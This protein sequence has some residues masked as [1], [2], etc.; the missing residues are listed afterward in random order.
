MSF[1][2]HFFVGLERKVLSMRSP[3]R[4]RS[5]FTLIELLVVIAII[6]ILIA[7]LLPAVQQAR[8]AARRS[9]CKNNL[10]QL[11]LALHNY[12][13][14][15]NQF[16]RGDY[17]VV[18]DGKLNSGWGSEWEG[19]SAHT[20]LLP[21]LDQGPVYN[22]INFQDFWHRNN[23]V[24]LSRTKI[25]VF[26]CPSTRDYPG[27]DP[28]SNYAVSTGPMLGWLDSAA[29]S[30]GM[31]SKRSHK[32]FRD[33]TD[34][35]SNTIAAGE[36]ITGDASDTTYTLGD[37]VRG[38]ARVMS[39]RNPTQAQVEQY[40]TSCVA[41]RAN[42]TSRTGASWMSPMMYSTMFNTIVPPNSKHDTC[43]ECAGCGMGDANGLYPAR[44]QHTGG[45]HHL[46]GDGAVRFIS[47]NIDFA[48][49]QGLGSVGGNET[50]GEF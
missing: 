12:H 32:G 4:I 16:P 8:E 13:D 26:R 3:R 36:I 11:G 49:Y 15:F 34:G 17:G 9:Q 7:L 50:I 39:V 33:I 24:I 35:S 6:A 25:A 38:V 27:T 20:M 40:A 44:S 18:A 10:K 47:D 43:H 37:L 21:Y 46:M 41:A 5:A 19:F 23:N 1:C 30:I 29:D 14:V 31:F 48:T 22:Q 28:G 45:A 2:F 42:H